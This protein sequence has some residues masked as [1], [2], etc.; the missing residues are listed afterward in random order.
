[1]NKAVFLD[2]DGVINEEI[3]YLHEPEKTVIIPGVPEALVRFHRAGFLVII[4]TNQSGVARGMFPVSCVHP[5]H[6]RIQR[7]LL[8]RGGAEATFDACYMCCHHEKYTGLC[9]CRKPAP[10]MLLQAAADFHIDLSQSYMAGDRLSD[11]LAGRNAGCRE[12]FLVRTG[13]GVNEVAKAGEAEFPVVDDLPAVAEIIA[14]GG[15]KCRECGE[16]MPENENILP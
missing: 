4:V 10:G 16:I 5:V 7:L 1:M 12:S 14:G 2:R 15:G 9:Q 11:L 6:A 13:Y 8:S 3:N